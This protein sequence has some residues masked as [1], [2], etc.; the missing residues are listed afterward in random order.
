MTSSTFVSTQQGTH[1]DTAEALAVSNMSFVKGSDVT[2]GYSREKHLLLT[3]PLQVAVQAGGTPVGAD[4]TPR[5]A[6]AAAG[7]D[8]KVVDRPLAYDTTP[9]DPTG[10]DWRCLPSHK[11][12]VREDTNQALGVVS[13]TYQAIQNESL[14][15]L[16]EFLREDAKLD[17]IISIK[18]GKKIFATA[19]IEISGCVTDGDIIRR[20]LHAFNSFDGSTSFGVFFSDMRV[21]CAN[22]LRHITGKGARKAKA[23]GEGLVFRHTKQVKDFVHRLP[24]SSTCRTRA[25]SRIWRSCAP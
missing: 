9:E 5:Q 1:A 24:S 12:I 6:F 2:S 3:N 14:I 20:H 4:A 10:S 21:I 19:T 8:F 7:A 22:Q 13:R 25:S 15:Q 11:A 17:N 23:A 18:G 16:F